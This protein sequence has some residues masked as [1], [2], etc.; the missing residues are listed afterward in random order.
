MT[1]NPRQQRFVQEYLLDLNA[2]QAAIR[3]GYNPCA[4]RVQGHRMITNDNI[5]KNI[6]AAMDER[7]ERTRIASDRVLEELSLIGFANIAD[8][9]G[10]GVDGD[11]RVDLS[12]LTR[13]Q[14][15]ALTYVSIEK[16][17]QG[18]KTRFRLD[19]KLPAL[20]AMSRHLE[21]A[22]TRAERGRREQEANAAD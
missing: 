8:Y 22:T 18:R 4:A 15:A 9:L 14:A 11:L 12:N 1:L 20:V 16:S 5:Q 13:E 2:T 17:G 10:K 6:Q 7:A 19:G 21:N 3:A